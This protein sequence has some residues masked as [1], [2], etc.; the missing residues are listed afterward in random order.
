[1]S[2]QVPA[3]LRAGTDAV[4]EDDAEWLRLDVEGDFSAAVATRVDVSECR[5]QG[6]SFTSTDLPRSRIGDTVFIGCELSGAAF[7]GA[8]LTRVEFRE[9]RMLG[10]SLAEAQ[11]RDVQF[12]DCRLEGANLRMAAGERVAFERC[13][14]VGAD[15]YSA[16]LAQL[17]L[18]DCDLTEVE[19]SQADMTGARLHGSTLESLR[20]ARYL[21]GVVIDS[22]QIVPLAL[23][24]FSATGVVVDDE[25]A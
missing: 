6:A 12:T 10:F 21:G 15:L 14:M 3:R 2:A 9:C 17:R 20:G 19:F 16:H 11:L 8:A 7:H 13:D 1:V 22:D 18:F 25:R 24:M 23:Q 5:I 4:L